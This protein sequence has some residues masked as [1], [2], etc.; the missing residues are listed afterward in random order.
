[1]SMCLYIYIYIYNIGIRVLCDV[2]ISDDGCIWAGP[3]PCFFYIF[4]HLYE[5]FYSQI[6]L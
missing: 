2:R 1:M 6:I 5:Y 3:T 4:I